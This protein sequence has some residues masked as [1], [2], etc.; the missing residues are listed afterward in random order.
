MS[1]HG[2]EFEALF[3]Q[4]A[5]E[6]LQTLR[7]YANALFDAHPSSEHVERLYVAAH[8]LKGS[9]AM[10]GYPLFSAIAAKLDHAFQY[11]ANIGIKPE[12]AAPLVEFVSEAVAVLEADLLMVSDQGAENAEEIAAFRQKVFFCLSG[13]RNSG[14]GRVAGDGFFTGFSFGII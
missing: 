1:S 7:E 12:A 14:T 2:S 5:S 4:E 11:V 6:H 13:K 3:L 10:Y 9:S 8:T